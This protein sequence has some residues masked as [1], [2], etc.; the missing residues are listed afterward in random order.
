ME[1]SS[2]VIG[3]GNEF[4]GDDAVGLHVARRV[5]ALG[6]P[7]VITRQESGEGAALI[8]LFSSA[9]RVYIADAVQPGGRSG[10]IYRMDANQGALP[11]GFF[12]CSTHAFSVAEAVEMARALGQLPR[13][14]ILYGVEGGQFDHGASLS[15]EVERAAG[16]VVSRIVGDISGRTLTRP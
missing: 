3:I 16:E 5:A 13:K 1:D 2:L 11:G 7:G 6:L 12:G 14:L 8:E 15:R 10:W 4:R 9:D